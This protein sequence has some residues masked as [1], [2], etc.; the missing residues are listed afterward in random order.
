ML[1]VLNLEHISILRFLEAKKNGEQVLSINPSPVCLL[2]MTLHYRGPDN[3]SVW[4]QGISIVCIYDKGLIK[5]IYIG[6]Y[7]LTSQGSETVISRSGGLKGRT[8]FNFKC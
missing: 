6:L 4:L 5:Y 7:I 3:Y 1:S 8:Y 2:L